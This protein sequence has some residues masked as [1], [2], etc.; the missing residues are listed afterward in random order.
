MNARS[1]RKNVYQLYNKIAGWF[2]LNRPVELFEKR[3]L[4]AVNELIPD[5]ADILDLGCGN[6]KPIME[7]FI[8]LGFKVTGVDASE[9]MLELAKQNFPS[10]IFLLQDMRN[11]TLHNKFNAII[12]WHSLFHLPAPD[13]QKMFESFA[14]YLLPEGILLFTS[15]TERGEA[16]GMNGG[17][18]LFHASLDTDEYRELLN[19]HQFEILS[20]TINDPSCGNAT[21]WLARFNPQ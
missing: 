9:K 5:K 18:N 6:G 7:Y 12:A 17:E 3:H 14:N 11:L 15:G 1:K 2:A 4:D 19:K 10:E 8:H 21:V 20:H 16:W 13:Q